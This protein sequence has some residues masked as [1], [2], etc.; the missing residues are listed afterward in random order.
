MGGERFLSAS[1]VIKAIQT[2]RKDWFH[3]VGSRGR[4]ELPLFRTRRWR[5]GDGCLGYK[6]DRSSSWLIFV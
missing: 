2:A 6:M 3:R 1:L 5:R 4:T